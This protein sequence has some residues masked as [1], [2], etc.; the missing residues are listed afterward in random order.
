[1]FWTKHNWALGSLITISPG[2]SKIDITVPVGVADSILDGF[3][4]YQILKGDG[5]P[6][7]PEFINVNRSFQRITVETINTTEGLF[8]LKL[9]YVLKEHVTVFSDR[10]VFNDVIY[11]KPTGYRQERIK[12][13]GFRTV[14]WDGDYTSPGFLFD[15]VNI[16]IWK[17]FTDYRLGDIVAYKSYNWTSLQNQLGIEIFDD[18]KWSK[19]D[20]TPEKQLISNFDYKIKEFSDFFEVS[21]EGIGQSQ[22]ELARHTIGYQTRDY[23]QNLS[24]DPVTQFQLYQGFIREKG[25]A[26]AI[27]KVFGKLVVLEQIVL[28]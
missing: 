8:Y 23:L 18:S 1:M 6:L 28:Y 2:A 15:N 11:D 12:T 25:T 16:A 13:Q 10:T 21:S 27:T 7:S 20:V 3:Y 24:E 5:Q 4:D 26:N 14:D 17:P 19:L 9:Y 22:R